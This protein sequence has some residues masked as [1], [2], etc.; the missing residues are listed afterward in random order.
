MAY[1]LNPN[2]PRIQKPAVPPNCADDF[3][4]AYPM[5]TNLNYCCRP[6]TMIYGTAPY[7]S[8]NGA[9]NELMDVSDELR[10]QSTTRFDKPLIETY[11]RDLFPLQD[12]KCSIPLRTISY[13]PQSSRAD[14]QNGLFFKR[15]CNK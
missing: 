8:G 6:S 15:Y 9:P 7:M 13:E 1:Q 3:V 14:L 11:K 12:M 4:F 2:L 5:P 10:P